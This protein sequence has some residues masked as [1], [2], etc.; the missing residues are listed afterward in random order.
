MSV[1]GRQQAE[2]GQRRRQEISVKKNK[3]RK[4]ERTQGDH[5]QILD[6]MQAEKRNIN[7]DEN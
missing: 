5:T 6:F 4:P 1:R 2:H 3:N 7:I